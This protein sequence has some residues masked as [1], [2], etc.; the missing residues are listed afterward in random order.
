M[1]SIHFPSLKR[2]CRKL[3]INDVIIII[4]QAAG[5]ISAEN[6]Q[7]PSTIGGFVDLWMKRPIFRIMRSTLETP[8][9]FQE[10]PS[11]VFYSTVFTIQSV[12]HRKR[13]KLL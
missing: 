1:A 9:D 11:A 10:F 7:L 8:R 5:T 6:A 2:D 3:M 12:E 4:D 13:I